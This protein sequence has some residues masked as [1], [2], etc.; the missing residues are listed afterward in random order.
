MKKNNIAAQPEVLMVYQDKSIVEMSIKQIA[1]L[2]LKFAS[3]KMESTDLKKVQAKKP[4][5]LLISSNDVK[6]S[7]QYYIDYLE[8]YEQNIPPH[9]AVLLINHRETLCAY[10]AC[11]NGLLTITPSSTHSMNPTD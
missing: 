9:R 10:L 5:V 4:K 3:Y 2:K 11:E 7:I 1:E 8:E 6:H